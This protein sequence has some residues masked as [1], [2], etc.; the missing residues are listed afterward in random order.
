[1]HDVQLEAGV[2]LVIDGHAPDQ[3]IAVAG[4]EAPHVWP[5]ELISANSIGREN[6][7]KGNA[8][9]AFLGF[10]FRGDLDGL[11]VIQLGFAMHEGD[12]HRIGFQIIKEVTR[13]GVRLGP[14]DLALFKIRKVRR[15]WSFSSAEV[16]EDKS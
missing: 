8:P 1:M 11:I 2:R 7:V 16:S 4:L 6:G 5:A 3:V 13:P 10:N 15:W 12:M 9:I 14:G